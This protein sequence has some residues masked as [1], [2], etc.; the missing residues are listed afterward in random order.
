MN[1]Q[2]FLSRVGIGVG[3]IVLT[4]CMTACSS[5]GDDTPAPSTPGTGS[6]GKTNLSLNL[7]DAANGALKQNGGFLYKDGVIIARTKDG[8][9]IAVA[10]ACTHQGTTVQFDAAGNRLHCP[11]H[12]SNFKID[13]SVI[14]G[15]AGS[16]L[17]KF[18]TS[19]DAATNTLKVTE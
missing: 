10:Q 2:E 19:F 18:K 15:P 12:G 5:G 4:H 17:K 16:P 11:N 1:R 8:E 7:N 13:G 14:N 9:F 6:G 3:A